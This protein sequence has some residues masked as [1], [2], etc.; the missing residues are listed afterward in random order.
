MSGKTALVTGGAVGI[1]RAIVLAL[2]EEKANVVFTWWSHE[3]DARSLVRT[4]E[5]NGGTARALRLD[6]SSS[7]EVDRVLPPVMEDLGSLD[8]LINNAGGLVDRVPVAEMTDA[9]WQRVFDLNV[10]TAF[11]LCRATSPWIAAGGRVVNVSSLAG[12]NG[13]GDG[14]TAYAAAKAALLGFTRALAKEW[15]PRSITVN[16]V[17]PGLI[18]DTPFHERFTPQEQQQSIIAGIPLGRP[19]LPRDVSGAVLWLCSEA[20]GFITGEVINMNGGVYFH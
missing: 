12:L 6:A 19:G 5:A 18:L 15:A 8:L 2:A 17:A 16:A 20:A 4:V 14:A 13:G 11:H 3:A 1:G 10:G 9:H 7:A